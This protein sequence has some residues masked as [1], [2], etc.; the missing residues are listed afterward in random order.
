M[1]K[2]QVEL[3]EN[4][5]NAKVVLSSTGI[6][7]KQNL[8]KQALDKKGISLSLPDIQRQFE[9]TPEEHNPFFS[10]RDSNQSIEELARKYYESYQNWAQNL[11]GKF[12]YEQLKRQGFSE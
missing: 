3:D 1:L 4:L 12:S 7:D 10:V 9:V 6:K 11:K 2:K 5:R 8:I